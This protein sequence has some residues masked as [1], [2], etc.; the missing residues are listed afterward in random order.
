MLISFEFLLS[1][2]GKKRSCRGM[3]P[4]ASLKVCKR[5]SRSCQLLHPMHT[6]DKVVFMGFQ[7]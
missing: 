5:D 1:L 6:I 4:L 7:Y 3:N 2:R